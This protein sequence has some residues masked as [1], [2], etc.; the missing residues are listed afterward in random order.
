[1]KTFKIEVEQGHMLA[2]AEKFFRQLLE[3]GVV[4]ALLLPQQVAS[5]K[6]VVP[7]LVKNPAGITAANPFAPVCLG[8]TARLVSK[9]TAGP[10][11]VKTGVVLRPCEIKALVELVKLQQAK[12]DNIVVLGVDCLGT[13]EPKDY[14]RLVTEKSLDPAAW[15]VKA[16]QTGETGVKDT[17][18]RRSCRTCTAVVPENAQ[19]YLQWIGVGADQQLIVQADEAMAGE[20]AGKLALAETAIPAGRETLLSKLKQ[21]RTGAQAAALAEFKERAGSMSGLSEVLASCLKCQNCRQACPI[22][23]CREC[24]SASPLFEHSPEKYL[25]WAGRKGVVEMPTDTMLFHLTRVNHMGLSCVGCGQCETACPSDIPVSL[26]FQA[27][28]RSM[29]EI[30]DYHPGINPAEPLPLTT[31]QVNELADLTGKH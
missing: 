7:T 26:M 4:E 20:L 8:N 6:S 22:C 17:A 27:L 19:I 15:A 23:F 31:Y 13:F 12:L 9:L 25:N 1:M 5:G 16:G 28:S 3:Q 29:Q 30:F 24:V 14:S 11:P 21:A 2:A 10:L 18:V